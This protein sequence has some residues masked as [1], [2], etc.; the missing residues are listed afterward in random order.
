M[1]GASPSDRTLVSLNESRS[2][3][4][5][6]GPISSTLKLDSDYLGITAEQ[7]RESTMEAVLPHSVR[8]ISAIETCQHY[9]IS[10]SRGVPVTT[11]SLT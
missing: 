9:L 5:I 11:G 4:R 1:D 6:R 2:M 7:S 3:D 10:T 8:M